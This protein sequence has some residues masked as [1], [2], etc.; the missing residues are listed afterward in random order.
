[1]KKIVV[2]AGIIFLTL[3]ISF[4]WWKDGLSPVNINDNRPQIFVV[5][6]GQGIK[7]ISK[8]LRDTGL[9][10]NQ[11]VFFLLT[12]KLGLDKKIEAGDYKLYKSMSADEIANSLTHGT[13][14]IWV[15]IPEGVRALEIAD[16]LKQQI[17]S[18]DD[19]WKSKLEANEGYL[20]PDT[21]LIP[22]DADVDLIINILRNNFDQK[23]S[24]LG[25]SKSGLSEQEV[26]IIASLVER[27]AKFDK[28]RPLVASVIINR[29]NLGMGL[30]IDA[31]LQYA[32]GYQADEKRWWKKS[33]TEEDK[34]ISSPYNTYL[35]AGLPPT[36]IS[37]PGS[38]SL[39]AALNPATSNFLYYISDSKGNNHYATTLQGHEN[40]I[41]K[42]GL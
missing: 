38:A 10:R 12:K 8:N 1:M 39:L 20:F 41:K 17:P 40:N 32:L 14:D 34:A 36:P 13:H 19:S 6:P 15:T 5:S 33:L 18:Y 11:I 37:N 27:E 29:L 30:N 31:T 9:I 26:V 3:F 42:Y 24:K 22:R 2:T 23:Y 25:E 35:H 7:E 21:Y 16:I 4:V 28:D